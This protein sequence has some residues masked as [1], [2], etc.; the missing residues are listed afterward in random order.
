MGADA[1]SK[2]I[3]PELNSIVRHSAGVQSIKKLLSMGKSTTHLADR[4]QKC[5]DCLCDLTSST[6]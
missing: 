4:V 3:V 1:T 6:I 5:S 2:Y